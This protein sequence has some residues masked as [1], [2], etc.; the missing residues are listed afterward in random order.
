[1]LKRIALGTIRFYQKTA[2]PDHGPFKHLYPEGFCRY[3]PSCSEYAA[4]AIEMHGVIIGSGLG[5]W[6]ILR[7]NP[8]VR[9]GYDPPP[10]KLKTQNAKLKRT[11]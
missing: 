10:K 1:M 2:S 9:G 7:C 11:A 4:Q 6:R 5:A 8:W 3:Y